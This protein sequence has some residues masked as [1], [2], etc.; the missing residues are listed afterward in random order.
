MKLVLGNCGVVENTLFS[1]WKSNSLSLKYA[2]VQNFG[3]TL[4]CTKALEGVTVLL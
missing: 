1:A 2:M 4:H 3:K